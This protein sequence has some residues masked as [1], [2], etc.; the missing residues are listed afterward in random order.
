MITS[1]DP[2]LFFLSVNPKDGSMEAFDEVKDAVEHATDL[3][4]D[5]DTERLIFVAV[6]R[7]KVR[8]AVRVE[9]IDPP[10]LP[11]SGSPET[12]PVGASEASVSMRPSGDWERSQGLEHGAG[13]AARLLE[14]ATVA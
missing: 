3:V 9:P 7:A 10:P 6:P 4:K 2:K 14:G 5:Q 13:R 1:A 12:M 11:A 8:M